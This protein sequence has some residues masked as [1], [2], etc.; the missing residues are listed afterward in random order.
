MTKYN[1]RLRYDK[2]TD[3]TVEV[4]GLPDGSW[5]YRDDFILSKKGKA[6]DLSQLAMHRIAN[7][8]NNKVYS[9]ALKG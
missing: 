7:G 1:V 3:K 8:L 9:I 2:D 5:L 6:V 4:L